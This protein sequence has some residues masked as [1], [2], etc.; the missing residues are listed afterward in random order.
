MSGNLRV[1]TPRRD[2]VWSCR[3]IDSQADGPP[4]AG[5]LS[6]ARIN[7]QTTNVQPQAMPPRILVPTVATL[8]PSTEA[9]ATG[10]GTTTPGLSNREAGA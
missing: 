5:N 4:Q 8:S 1:E 7:T 3:C 2:A 9:P 6:R 10:P